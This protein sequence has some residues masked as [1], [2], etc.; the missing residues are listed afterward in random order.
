MDYLIQTLL[1]AIG[2]FVGMMIC[3]EIGQRLGLREIKRHPQNHLT[4]GPVEGAI[5]ALR[6]VDVARPHIDR[7]SK[8]QT[9][10]WKHAVANASV[11]G[12]HPDAARLLLPALNDMFDVTTRRFAALQMHPPKVI[13]VL[14]FGLSLIASLLAGR[15]L[16]TDKRTSLHTVLF[17]APVVAVIFVIINMEY[18]RHGLIPI[19]DFDQLLVQARNS[20]N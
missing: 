20:M 14:L 10:I 18:P 4:G 11:P 5:F 1:L 2:L 19:E 15:G 12:A 13:F 6:D 8:L 16:A 17:A 7:A 9:D 3:L